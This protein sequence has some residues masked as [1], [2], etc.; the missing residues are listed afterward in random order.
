M[1]RRIIPHMEQVQ[2]TKIKNGK[3]A[4]PKLLQKQWGSM[5]ILF[6]PTAGG[7]YL[8]PLVTPSP[9]AVERKLKKAG[10]TLA[11][12]DTANAVAWARKKVY[13]GRA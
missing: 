9:A 6:M 2:I 13:T 7:A 11:P 5:S 3:V 8:K 10:A 12:K 1:Y 4:V